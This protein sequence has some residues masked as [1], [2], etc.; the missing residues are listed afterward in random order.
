MFEKVE[1]KQTEAGVGKLKYIHLFFSFFNGPFPASF[2]L[3]FRLFNTLDS[4]Q[5]NVRYKSWQMTGFEPRTFDIGI[6]TS[7]N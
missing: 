7:T 5:I 2:F 4:K 1:N 6:D 3:Y